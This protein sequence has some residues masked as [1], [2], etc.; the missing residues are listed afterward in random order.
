LAKLRYTL[1]T[2]SDTHWMCLFRHTL[3]NVSLCLENESYPVGIGQGG[4]GI[5]KLLRKIMHKR[6]N[7]YS[8]VSTL[9][10]VGKNVVL[11]YKILTLLN[12]IRK[13]GEKAVGIWLFAVYFHSDALYRKVIIHREQLQLHY[14]LLTSISKCEH[15]RNFTTILRN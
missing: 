6:M 10:F 2:L 13:C 1:P 9:N 12:S 4:Q 14:N 3:V 8:K 11:L 15:C 5:P 7:L